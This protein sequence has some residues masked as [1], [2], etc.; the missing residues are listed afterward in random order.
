VETFE[1]KFR[2]IPFALLKKKKWPRLCVR[3][4]PANQA[5]RRAKERPDHPALEQPLR[6]SD[7]RLA[8][9]PSEIGCSI[10]AGYL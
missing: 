6:A 1:L 9:V 8:A 4:V 5:R 10:P 2:R 7:D 3:Q